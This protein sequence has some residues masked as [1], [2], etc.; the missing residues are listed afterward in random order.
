MC[1]VAGSFV[2]NAKVYASCAL[3][4]ESISISLLAK[5]LQLVLL[6]FFFPHHKT[7][8]FIFTLAFP[9][10]MHLWVVLEGKVRGRL[11]VCR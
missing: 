2:S 8:P 7:Q 10:F 5:N 11:S 6:L 4:L 1:S 3:C 9:A